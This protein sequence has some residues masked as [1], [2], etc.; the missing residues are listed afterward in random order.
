MADA[1][2]RPCLLRRTFFRGGR[3]VVVSVNERRTAPEARHRLQTTPKTLVSTDSLEGASERTPT[4]GARASLLSP[5]PH[6]SATRSGV[7]TAAWDPRRRALFDSRTR[8]RMPQR[9]APTMSSHAGRESSWISG[10]AGPPM[11]LLGRNEH[12]WWYYDGARGASWYSAAR[13]GGNFRL[14]GQETE[15]RLLEIG[16]SHK[17]SARG[18]SSS[19]GTWPRYPD[20]HITVQAG[21]ASSL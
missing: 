3:A 8:S 5:C 14:M 11:A 20:R 13:S 6:G 21:Q 15:L 17:R 10:H 12:K 7:L 18:A 16:G 19:R 9:P 2:A 4:A 1:R